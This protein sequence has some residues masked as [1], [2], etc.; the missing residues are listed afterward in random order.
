MEDFIRGGFREVM[1]K[2]NSH[3]KIKLDAACHLPPDLQDIILEYSYISDSCLDANAFTGREF[4]SCGAIIK[5]VKFVMKPSILL[6]S[7]TFL[8]KGDDRCCTYNNGLAANT[9]TMCEVPIAIV[10]ESLS[11]RCSFQIIHK[12]TLEHKFEIYNINMAWFSI[13]A[14]VEI[15]TMG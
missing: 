14:L 3:E 5:N 8:A 11:S 10:M 1:C 13:A 15:V 12:Y 2:R 7:F 9:W 4:W 6:P